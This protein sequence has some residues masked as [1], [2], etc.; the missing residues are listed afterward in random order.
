[1]ERVRNKPFRAEHLLHRPFE[2]LEKYELI[3]IET[4]LECVIVW[5]LP[6]N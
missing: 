6:V 4:V 1:M 5:E 3:L 2:V